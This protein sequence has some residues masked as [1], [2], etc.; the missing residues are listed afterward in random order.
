M[1]D[2]TNNTNSDAIDRIGSEAKTT[3]C[4]A[5]GGA[6]AFDP[7]TQGMKCPF[8][9]GTV[10][11]EMTTDHVVEID[12]SDMDQYDF[13]WDVKQHTIVCENCGGETVTEVNDET[14][15][16]AFCGSQHIIK[17]EE[18]DIGMRPQGVIPYKLSYDQAKGS[19]KEWI[20]K[21]FFAP[22]DLKHHYLDRHLKGVYIPYWT[23]DSDTFTRYSC[24]IGTY[25]YTG[26]G[27]KRQRHTRW[28]FH[29]GTY[30]EFFDDVLVPAVSHERLRF[31]K[32]IEPYNLS[33]VVD[34]KPDFLAG[35]FAQ[36]YTVMPNDA[37]VTA[38]TSMESEI[39]AS[40]K[41][42]LP[43][44]TYRMY[45]QRVNHNKMTFKHILLPVYLMSYTYHSKLYNVAINGQTG[46]VQG[47]SPKSPIKITLFTLAII[48]VIFGLYYLI[49][50]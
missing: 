7:E 15:Y 41:S 42:S 44:D 22:N 8:C 23:F 45:N 46:E 19:L 39:A 33:E 6:M 17:R 34:Y 48:A 1:D 2:M 11:I 29:S 25:Y 35:Y 10:S 49:N 21:R 20:R 32:R 5:C 36:K 9:G 12:L 14:Q 13:N 37:L 38:K 18:T 16:C 28:S 31:I 26:T 24:Q 43:G 40:V 4:G 30:A 47:Q 50:R 27:E 3:E